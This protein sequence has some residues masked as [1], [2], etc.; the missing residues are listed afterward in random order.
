MPGRVTGV[1]DGGW[2]ILHPTDFSEA[3]EVAFVHALKLTLLTRG[4]LHV[5]HVSAHEGPV[6]W[7]TFPGVREALERWTSLSRI[8]RRTRPIRSAS[9][10]I[11]GRTR[12]S[13]EREGE[14]RA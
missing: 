12:R 14:A 5:L 1:S 7:R 10:A 6:R 13:E 8:H 11:R 3:S 4:R 9:G 2:R